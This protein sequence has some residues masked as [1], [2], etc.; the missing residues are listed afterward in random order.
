MVDLI[1]SSDCPVAGK[2][3]EL[4]KAEIK[5]S[6]DAVQRVLSAVQ[7]FTNPFDI[8]DKDRLYSLA[9]GA[10]TP[11]DVEK[12]VLGAEEVGEAAKTAFIERLKTG[13]S[14]GFF[15]AIKRNKLKTMEASNKKVRLTSSQGKVSI[16]YFDYHSFLFRCWV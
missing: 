9:S 15:G 1:N 3:R 5:K 14:G 11:S 6:E 2:H 4:E 12:D 10:P 16:S 8:A 7:N 13:E